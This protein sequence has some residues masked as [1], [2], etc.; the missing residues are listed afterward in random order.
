MSLQLTTAVRN[1]ELDAIAA[2]VGNAGKL[3]IYTGPQP[4]NANLVATGTLLS[5]HTLD[6]PFAPA[7]SGGVLTPTLPADA[8]AA[9]S[10]TALYFR[11][12]KSDD[13][14]IG[15]GTVADSGTPDCTI[16]D[17]DIIAGFPVR[18]LSWAWT[19]G[20]Q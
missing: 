12:T 17:A 20:A 6:S 9:A 18:V 1:A 16:N 14:V 7:A 5:T 19:A 13:T 4:A 8:T 3:K 2:Q 15:Q 11:V 10:G